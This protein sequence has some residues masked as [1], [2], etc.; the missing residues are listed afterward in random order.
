MAYV[1][2][3]E[4]RDHLGPI[5]QSQTNDA[6]LALALA[7]A[8]ESVNQ[9]CGRTFGA[10]G[11]SETRTFDGGSCRILIDDC[12]AFTA[13]THSVD[14]TTF[15][16][17]TVTPWLEPANTS[18]KTTLVATSPFDRWVRVTGT[19]GYGSTPS[20]VKTAT[21]IKA[22]RI[23]KRRESP[24]GVEGSSEFGLVRITRGEDADCVLLLSPYVRADRTMGLA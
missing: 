12:S 5:A 17:V 10:V 21:L 11:A 14:R 3:A 13:V 24:T 15:S 6:M 20:S 1:T 9:H 19:F 18:P 4:F 22:A 16:A 8:E 7:A 23:F 2:L